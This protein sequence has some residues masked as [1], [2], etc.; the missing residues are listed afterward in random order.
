[1]PLSERCFQFPAIED[2]QSR[3]DVCSLFGDEGNGKLPKYK[4]GLLCLQPAK[5]TDQFRF[6]G[7]CSLVCNR[8]I[9]LSHYSHS[10]ASTTRTTWYCTRAGQGGIAMH[11]NII[12]Y[13]TTR[14]LSVIAAQVTSQSSSGVARRL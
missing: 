9:H 12:S 8:S 5:T 10:C 1:M 2:G 6:R 14:Y 3:V 13:K 4:T 11:N 7:T